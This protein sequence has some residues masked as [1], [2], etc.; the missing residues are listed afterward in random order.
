MKMAVDKAL[1]GLVEKYFSVE[2]QKDPNVVP[3][4]NL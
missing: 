2:G 3:E 1:L 4:T